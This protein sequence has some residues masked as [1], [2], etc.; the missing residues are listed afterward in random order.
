MIGL[1]RQTAFPS[2]IIAKLL[3]YLVLRG[4]RRQCR[5]RDRARVAQHRQQP[6]QRR[7]VARLDG[8]LPRSVPEVPLDQA[9][10]EIAQLRAASCDPTQKIADQAEAPPSALAS[11]PISDDTRRVELD[12]LSVGS[13]LQSC[14]NS[15]LLFKYSSAIIV[16]SSAFDCGGRK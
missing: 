3:E 16:L 6:F 1:R 9:F 2:Q 13:T 12:E 11:E 10:I 14:R 4:D 8:L 7:P 5:R 15:R